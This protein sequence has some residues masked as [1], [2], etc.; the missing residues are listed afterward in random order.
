MDTINKFILYFF[1][2]NPGRNFEYYWALGAIILVFIILTGLI[3]YYA[4]KNKDD[5]AFKKLFRNYPTKFIILAVLF[6]AY[7]L[8]RYNYVPFF[9]MRFLMYILL[10]SSVFVLYNSYITYFKKYPEE[11]KRREK[12]L[13]I[14]KY[15]PKKKKKKKN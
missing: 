15:I 5:K 10:I 1:S 2:P 6:A 8:V 11:K 4:L 7:I 9:S 14:N 12:R 3:Y 13:Q